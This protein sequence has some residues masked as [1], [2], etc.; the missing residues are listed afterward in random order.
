MNRSRSKSR[1]TNGN[2]FGA[3]AIGSTI[4]NP[5]PAM[6]NNS[7]SR[8]YVK[9]FLFGFD[10]QYSMQDDSVLVEFWSFP[11]STHPSELFIR[12]MLIFEVPELTFP[13]NSSMN[14]GLI[15]AA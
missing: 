6:S 13:T 14:L 1:E 15:P 2:I 11:G 10:V 5:L 8:R 7:L 9:D 12:A 4:L 3:S